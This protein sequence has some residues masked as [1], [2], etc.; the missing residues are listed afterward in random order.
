MGTSGKGLAGGGGYPVGAQE[1]TISVE[2]GVSTRS[3][4]GRCGE[5]V[6]G[7]EE[8]PQCTTRVLSLSSMHTS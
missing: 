6:R 4:P 5:A 8:A 2:A 7:W 1:M 3:A